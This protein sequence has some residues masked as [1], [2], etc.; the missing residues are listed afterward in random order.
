VLV[1]R[2]R[3]KGKWQTALNVAFFLL[4]LRFQ[5][6]AVRSAGVDLGAALS[7]MAGA[8]VLAAL[9]PLA[10]LFAFTLAVP[11]LTGLSQ[12]IFLSC[13]FP[14]SLVFSALWMGI[15][16]SKLLA[17]LKRRSG[18][19][20]A[21][22]PPRD[23]VAGQSIL[24]AGLP[25]LVAD[26]LISSALLSLAWQ[27]WRHREG[28][29]LREAFF[30]R[31]V[32]GFGDPWY[33]LTSAFL[34]LQGL[35]YFRTL[36]SE[37]EVQAASDVGANRCSVAIASWVRPVFAAYG[38]TLVTFILMQY[39]V[40]IPEGWTASGF[41]APYEDISSFGSIAVAIFIY[42]V[43]TRVARSRQLFAVNIIICS[44]LLLMVVASWSR[45]TWLAALVF[46]LLI[47]AFRLPRLWAAALLVTL[48]AAV[49]SIDAGFS[50][51]SW[52]EQPYIIR[53]HTLLRIENPLHKDPVRL[54]LY[55][56]AGRMIEQRPIVGHGIGSFY[57]ESLDYA[58]P[59][60][61]YATVPDFAHNVFLQ[62]ATEEGLPIAALFGCLLI[63]TL[64]RG[65]AVWRRREAGGQPNSA[66]ALLILGVTLS[67]AAYV[68]TQMTANSLNVY[69]SNQF[70]FWF[71]MASILALSGSKEIREADGVPAALGA[72]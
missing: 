26:I 50:R 38:L 60:D 29:G 12:N 30:D 34:W 41:Q 63:G 37:W 64:W 4:C 8:F 66:H 70:F 61:P 9:D 5:V 7:L 15:G 71:A 48:V 20:D 45:A 13:A 18:K 49:A 51:A 27:L 32:L 65:L 43:A 54:N 67:L 16:A 69:A 24:G 31:A 72:G 44:S 62:I 25:T 3:N 53:L 23:A 42:A 68:E 36:L 22:R 40:G 11:L 52:S 28:T 47:A 6:A 1:I 56:K 35:F 46:L 58:S 17:T 21:R 39:L 55:A 10:S 14:P 57:L 33:F 2:A 19:S 59:N